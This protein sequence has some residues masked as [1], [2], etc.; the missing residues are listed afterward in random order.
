MGFPQLGV[1]VEGIEGTDF[2]PREGNGFRRFLE[3]QKGI[4]KSLPAIWNGF[5]GLEGR[6][7]LF[8]GHLHVRFDMFRCE[9]GPARVERP[10][11]KR[12]FSL[13]MFQAIRLM[14]TCKPATKYPG[15][16]LKLEISPI[17]RDYHGME[18]ARAITFK[19]F[20]KPLEVLEL[21]ERPVREPA[22]GEVRL[23][24]LAAPIHPS[25]FGI[26]LGKYGKLPELPAVAGREGVAEI[27]EL[28]EGVEDFSV[29]ERVTI[30]SGAGCWQTSVT[31][32]AEGLFKVPS[33]I[34]VEIAAMAT[35]N[36]P[37]AWRLLRDANLG[38][39]DWVIQNAA[40]S[41]VG[42]HVIEMARHLDLKTLNV[43][44]REELIQ[45]LMD[46]GADVVVLEDSGYEKKVA[47]LTGG[48]PV[49][50]ALNSVGGESGIRLV[51]TLAEDGVHVTFG[52]MQFDAVRFP[53]RELIFNNVV[54]RG[55]WMDKW[56][57]TNSQARVQ[58]MYDKVF[59]LMR[60]GIVKASV[61][62]V[63]SI[64][65]YKAAIEAAGKP[66]LGKI[67]FKFAE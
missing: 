38:A 14:L 62:S 18:K 4:L 41:A 9:R 30:P 20:G 47:E 26:I 12:V 25:D 36:P 54:L 31:V 66:R 32:A 29:G 55:F 27:V 45:P 46:R 6:G 7:S 40:N 52:A 23:R 44:R 34:P 5:N 17:L 49:K 64:D 3:R 61:E 57:R 59:D 22:S 21:E 67:L 58:I 53:T 10:V 24:I 19:Q 39:G 60:K 15:S 2:S 1:I 51:R 28:G 42:L 37:T 50:L 63:Y 11:E 16:G 43:V 13:H 56:H 8:K 48:Q 35:V 33:D 65:D